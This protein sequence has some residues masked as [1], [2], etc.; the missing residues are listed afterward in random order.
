MRL[1]FRHGGDRNADHP[2]DHPHHN[3]HRIERFEGSMD[4]LVV[5]LIAILAL[6]MLVGLVTGG[7]EPGWMKSL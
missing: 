6:A 2:A 4:L 3:K 7:G 1:N 5:G